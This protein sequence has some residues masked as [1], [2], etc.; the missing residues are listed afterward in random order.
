M[1]RICLKTVMD[2]LR[3]TGVEINNDKYQKNG[4]KYLNTQWWSV[5]WGNGVWFK[6]HKIFQI[7]TRFAGLFSNPELWSAQILINNK[8]QSCTL[9]P[10]CATDRQCRTCTIC[11]EWVYTH[12]LVRCTVVN[13]TFST[14]CTWRN[15]WTH[16]PSLGRHT[17]YPTNKFFIAQQS[18]C[19]P[20]STT[21][22]VD[23]ISPSWST[24][25]HQFTGSQ[26][27][28]LLHD[29]SLDLWTT[30]IVCCDQFP[31]WSF[32]DTTAAGNKLLLFGIQ[33][34]LEYNMRFFTEIWCLSTWDHLKFAYKVLKRTVPKWITL[35]RNTWS[36]T[37]FCITK[38]ACEIPTLLRHYAVY[39]SNSLPMFHDNLLVPSSID[40]KSKTDQSMTKVTWHTLNFLLETSSII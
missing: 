38:L 23:S 16:F 6:I 40:K 4:G 17:S 35:N 25:R 15:C 1:C 39:S 34:L 8:K 24:L 29:L 28:V 12:I 31:H 37:K 26:N 21:F 20:D 30:V 33:Y 3:K 2:E 5:W 9:W 27:S 32:D 7:R 13:T 36:Q 14:Q 11:L 18:S 19:G 10:F 22:C